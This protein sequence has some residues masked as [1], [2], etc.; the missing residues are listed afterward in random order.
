MQTLRKEIREI[1]TKH[2]GEVREALRKLREPDGR[3]ITITDSKGKKVEIR[4]ARPA[5]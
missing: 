5:E 3:G 1:V 2:Q 4:L